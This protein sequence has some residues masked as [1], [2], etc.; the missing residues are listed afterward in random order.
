MPID[1]LFAEAARQLAICNACRYCEGYCPVWPELA[2]RS[3]L[4]PAGIR[5]LASLC[6]DCRDCVHACPYTAPHEFDLNPPHVF[7]EV[8]AETYAHYVRPRR[9]PWLTGWRGTGTVTAGCGLL[10]AVL[11]LLTAGAGRPGPPYR[12][13]PYPLLLALALAPAAWSVAVLAAAGTRYWRDIRPGRAGPAVW[14]R[15]LWQAGTLAHLRG[16]GAGCDYP[17]DAPGP[18]R[19]WLHHAVAYGFGLCLLATL[20]AA[21]EQDVL[22]RPPPYPLWSVPVTA[23]TLGGAAMTAGC[24]GLLALKR[25][26]AL[27]T[28]P[29][30]RADLAMLT[31][32]LTLAL[33]GLLSLALRTTPAADPVLAVHL[34]AVLASFTLAPYTRWV[35]GLF[36][37][38]A[39][40][41]HEAGRAPARR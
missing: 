29:T 6:H 30:Y 27:T 20:A 19:R 7:T 40:A 25:P 32:L 22:H 4:D 24:A 12:L 36:R 33:T 16:G 10:V 26:G 18:A 34:A 17:A 15:A 9:P 1:D 37:L 31:A 11:A 8:R 5:H 41:A 21:A 23:G 35:H 3:R 2:G 28:G 13:L 38:L 39:I 14:A